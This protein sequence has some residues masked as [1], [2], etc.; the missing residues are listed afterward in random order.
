MMKYS[1]TLSQKINR[2]GIWITSF[3]NCCH[4]VC[5]VYLNDTAF[6]F[7]HQQYSNRAALWKWKRNLS[8]LQRMNKNILAQFWVMPFYNL[9]HP[10]H[11]WNVV[12]V[13]DMHRLE[14]NTQKYYKLWK[15]KLRCRNNHQKTRHNNLVNQCI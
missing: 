8:L 3:A 7:T 15:T 13:T 9:S 1:N 4:L 2:I 5:F 14:Q 10:Q 11:F 12:H 6:D